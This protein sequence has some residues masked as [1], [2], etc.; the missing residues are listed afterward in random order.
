MIHIIHCVHVPLKSETNTSLVS[1]LFQKIQAFCL[2][3]FLFLVV[4]GLELG[5]RQV[6]YHLSHSYFGRSSIFYLTWLIVI[7]V[8][9]WFACFLLLHFLMT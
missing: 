1:T 7:L 8:E 3:R 4:L 6:L 5:A 9:N 2:V